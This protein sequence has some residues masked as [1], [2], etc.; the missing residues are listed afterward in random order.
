MRTPTGQELRELRDAA[1]ITAEKVTG[2]IGVDRGQF[3]R[4]E[5]GLEGLPEKSAKAA[6]VAVL[7]LWWERGEQVRKARKTLH[8]SGASRGDAR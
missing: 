5:R 8:Y 2:I 1:G 6:W 7:K 4:W 3:S